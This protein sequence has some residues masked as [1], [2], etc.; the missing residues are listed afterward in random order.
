M[1]S[2]RTIPDFAKPTAD[3]VR[4]PP[5]EGLKKPKLMTSR[6]LKGVKLGVRTLEK[7]DS[8]FGT[9]TVHAVVIFFAVAGSSCWSIVL[10]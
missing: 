10:E 4:K 3:L 1:S 2:G 5:T 6:D 9:V 8:I 7:R